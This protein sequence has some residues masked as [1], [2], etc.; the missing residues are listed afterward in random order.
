MKTGA[1]IGAEAEFADVVDAAGGEAVEGGKAGAHAAGL[2]Q[3][4][5][6]PPS[7][8]DLVADIFVDL[9]ARFD[10][11]ER[12]VRDE[13]IEEVHEAQLAEALRDRGGRAHVDE[14]QRALLD[15]RAVIAS[16]DEG[17]EHA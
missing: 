6:E 11:G 4:G 15:A 12:Q 16:G 10:D 17:E 3:A 1:E 5:G 8:D 13:A 7:G 14:Q 9:A 2:V